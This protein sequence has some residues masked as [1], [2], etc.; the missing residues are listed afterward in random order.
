V[1]SWFFIEPSTLNHLT[2]F[3]R[4]EKFG[5]SHLSAAGFQPNGIA[6][7]ERHVPFPP[8]QHAGARFAP[9]LLGPHRHQKSAIAVGAALRQGR[10]FLQRSPRRDPMRAVRVYLRAAARTFRLNNHAHSSSYPFAIVGPPTASLI[11]HL[12][13]SAKLSSAACSSR[14]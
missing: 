2:P 7:F 5:Y 9:C 8:S 14:Q 4:F 3:R 10:K 12:A 1:L 6:D 13:P 11:L